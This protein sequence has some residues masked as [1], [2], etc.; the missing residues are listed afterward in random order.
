MEKCATNANGNQTEKET[1][2]TTFTKIMLTNG[3]ENVLQNTNVTWKKVH[4][5]F[6]CL[7]I[8]F[9]VVFVVA[10][11]SSCS[12]HSCWCCRALCSECII[13]LWFHVW[14]NDQRQRVSLN[15][16]FLSSS[17]FV[18]SMKG[19]NNRGKRNKRDTKKK[20]K[21]NAKTLW[22][23]IHQL[24]STYKIAKSTRANESGKKMRKL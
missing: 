22:M 5:I 20:C 9:V 4:H 15:F 2:W 24:N 12:L 13:K 16:F 10:A 1:N 19:T 3:R 7:I 6:V 17:S 14:W 11:S 8:L 21:I 18:L 23:C